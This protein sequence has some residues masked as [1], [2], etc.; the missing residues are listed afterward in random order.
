[1]AMAS[2]GGASATRPEDVEKTADVLNRH[3][4]SVGSRIA[5]DLR[6]A[7]NDGSKQ[8]RPPSVCATGFSFQTATLPELSQC[9]KRM[10][11]SRAVGLD[12]VPLQA[13]RE[14]FPV[15]GPHLLKLV[16]LSLATK[17][18]PDC[19]KIACVVPIP[20]SSKPVAPSDYRPIS[21][22]SVLSKILEKV[23]CTQLINYLTRAGLLHPSQYAYRS[24][25][26]TEDAVLTAVEQLITNTDEGMVSSVTTID[27]SKAFDSVDHDVLLTKLSWYGVHDVNWFR[28]Y[29]SG[30]KQLVRGGRLICPVTCGVP[31]GSIIG[32]ILFIL[33]TNDLFGHLTHG[34]FISY[35][36]D[37]LHIDC[38]QTDGPSLAGLKVRLEHT[39][40][41]LQSWF[42]SNSL[43]MNEEKTNFM[44][45]GSKKNLSKTETFRFKVNG[46]DVKPSSNIKILGVVVDP[47]LSWDA[48]V[49]SVS[50]KCNGI[51]VSL[52]KVRHYF[53]PEAL[54]IIIQAYVFPHIMYC[55][56]VWGGTA[57]SQLLK[58]KKIINFAARIVTGLKKN[59]HITQALDSV[60]FPNIETLVAQRDAIKVFKALRDECA[61]RELRAMFTPRFAV[62]N[63]KTRS[64]DRLHLQKCRL[65]ASQKAFS[66]RA[67]VIWN[68]L[69]PQACAAPSLAAFKTAI[70]NCSM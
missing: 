67:A 1:M 57:K 63:R 39:L 52:Y 29:L 38:A 48:H 6:G 12:E 21:L 59:E 11:A 2:G 10:R 20:K 69:P 9:I 50:K 27:L 8:P 51:L 65:T 42:C 13:V 56:C 54:K 35:A 64:S 5:A 19:W 7:V 70:Q 62:C 34:R 68:R 55:L 36:D 58:V 61:P 23:V 3:F 53:T 44:L 4:S 31:Q 28:S 14:C 22:L 49:S 25:H 60:G 16:N 26:S 47:C 41:E 24:H 15:I 18:F 43:K 40:N 37:T 30:R 46:S 33:F 45:V 66:Y 32:P 17:E